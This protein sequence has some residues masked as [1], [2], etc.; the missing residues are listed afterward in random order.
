MWVSHE[1]LV[2]NLRLVNEVWRGGL[3][4]RPFLLEFFMA[5]Y[6][7]YGMPAEPR[8]LDAF[9]SMIPPGADTEWLALLYGC[10]DRAVRRLWPH[11]IGSGGH[12]RVGIGDNPG[13]DGDCIP[14]ARSARVE[15]M[16]TMADALGRNVAAVETGRACPIG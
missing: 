14:A 12:V 13:T 3:H 8:Y 15:Q 10:S 4:D 7:S 2:G 5:E 11:A 9:V 6:S 1:H 16:V